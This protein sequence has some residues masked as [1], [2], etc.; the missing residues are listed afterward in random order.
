M[1]DISSIFVHTSFVD[2]RKSM[3]GLSLLVA[4]S[5]D[6]F[7]QGK[8]FV[9]FNK[10]RD[11]IKILMKENNG[12]VLAYKRLDEGQ[13][14]ISFSPQKAIILTKQQLRWLLEGLDYASLTSSKTSVFK[15]YF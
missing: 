14:K 15:H 13:F 3:N 1:L 11:K 7:E 2:M 10:A 4:L 8:A 5:G 6:V 9:F 12:F